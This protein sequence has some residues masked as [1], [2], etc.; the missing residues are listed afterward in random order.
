MIVAYLL[1]FLAPL[2]LFE[3]DPDAVAT[4]GFESILRLGLAQIIIASVLLLLLGYL[5]WWKV[6]RLKGSNAGGLKFVLLPVAYTLLVVGIAFD[7]IST[8]ELDLSVVFDSRSLLMVILISFLIGF[9]EEVIFR[10]FAFGALA[11]KLSPLLTVLTCALLFGSFHFVNLVHG[12]A[13]D[14]TLSQVLQASSMGFLYAAL[15]LRLDSLWPLILLH[16]FWD[17]SVSMMQQSTLFA[18]VETMATSGVHP[19]ISMPVLL[20]GIFVYWRWSV[21]N[22][23]EVA[24]G[25][26]G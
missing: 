18:E 6:V 21:W 11:T 20:Y 13:F 14:I 23:K 2:L 9:N 5:G 24:G 15:R 3:A 4:V 12:Q 22:K 19:L 26:S 8:N 17:A 7:A 25:S 10:G 1:W 16:G